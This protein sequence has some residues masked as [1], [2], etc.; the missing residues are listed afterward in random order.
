MHP[1]P[2][3]PEDPTGYNQ[4][5]HPQ[6]GQSGQYGQTPH[7][8]P[9]T[10]QAPQAPQGQPS[11]QG[12]PSQQGSQ[13]HGHFAVPPGAP[14]T[15][16]GQPAPAPGTISAKRGIPA[17]AALSGMLVVALIAG[18]A[19][20]LAGGLLSSS[21][22]QEAPPP[23]EGPIINEPP[24]EAPERAPDTIAGVAQRVSPS[25]V[26]LR[27]AGGRVGASGSGF[28]IE[29]DY[30]VTNDHVSAP[31]EEDGIIIEYSDGKFSLGTVV[32]SDPSSDLAVLELE[33]P[34]D[35]EPLEFGNSDEAVVGDEVIAIGA[36]LGL[37]GTVTQG[38]ISAV[39]RPVS[40]DQGE[41]QF[42]ALQTDAAINPGNS[43]GPLVDIQ[44]RVI[45]VNS[46]IVTMGGGTM[47]EQP[48]GN[49]GLG[50]AIPST[51]AEQ[52]VNRMIDHGETTY[53]DLGVTYDQ[54]SPVI[55]AVI[56]DGP[57]AVET[58]GPADEAGLEPGD[59]IVSFDGR[60][61]NSHG[62]LQAMVRDREPGDEVE[63]EY[64]RDGER[65]TVNVTLGSAD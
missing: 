2:S 17:W 13:S 5:Q 21:G 37:A 41:S 9:Q 54:E 23:Q 4:G 7:Q 26:S 65:E 22:E 12:Q 55:G 49:I 24:P 14:A 36:P 39:E 28:V 33:D 56:D 59:V 6:Q 60:R 40:S 46:M 35:V 45:G 63:L 57:N 50:F 52:V 31:L 61:V 38:I 18:G 47:G 27:S 3:S 20:G 19:G 42:F 11:Y 58:G 44:G 43:G 51:E 62:E 30:V 29:G 25:V 64:E 48:G 1:N 32:G 15:Q 8:A 53:A 34:N 10:P 16:Y